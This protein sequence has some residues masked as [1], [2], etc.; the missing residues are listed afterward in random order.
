[1]DDYL[2]AISG[3]S[4]IETRATDKRVIF[5]GLSGGLLDNQAVSSIYLGEMPMS[6]ALNTFN[7][8]LVDIERVEVIKGAQGT[9]YGSAA[10]GGLIRN[11]PVA[12]SF[13]QVEGEIVFD[14]SS[15]AESNNSNNS[16]AGTLN[17][18]LIDDQVALRIAAYRT[19]NAGYVDSISTPNS[20]AIA[21]ATGAIGIVQDD[22]NASVVEG[23]RASMLWKPNDNLTLSLMLGTQKDD[24]DGSSVASLSSKYETPRL[25][26]ISPES[27]D[28][29]YFNLTAEYDMGW[30]SILSSTSKLDNKQNYE[31]SGFPVSPAFFAA[32]V[33]NTFS[34]TSLKAEEIRLITNLDGPWQVL[35]GLYYEDALLKSH[36]SLS[37]IGDSDAN[38]FGSE[39]LLESFVVLDYSQKAI[40][41]EA[42]YQFD[43]MWLLTLGGRYFDYDRVDLTT[44]NLSLPISVPES[45]ENV[46]QKGQTYKANLAFT[47]NEDVLIYAQWSEGFRLGKGQPL[48][49]LGLCDFPDGTKITT[50]VEPDTTKNIELGV[51][52]SAADSRLTINTAIFRSYWDN[53][54]VDID[55]TNGCLRRVINNI[56]AAESQ[57]IEID[58]NYII[59]DWALSISASYIDTKRVGVRSPLIEGE[60]LTYAPRTNASLGLQR[61]FTIDGIAAFVRADIAY[62]GE[63]ESAPVWLGFDS[64]GDYV[65]ANLRLGLDVEEW[66]FA[67]YA[68][69]L[70]NTNEV[71]VHADGAG[72]SGV[73]TRSH[74]RQFG[75]TLGYSF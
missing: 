67:I 28:T 47:P 39:D 40:F 70:T 37:W 6:N 33:G 23:A 29:D 58:A 68:K 24:I 59:D 34:S 57:G 19:D 14:T 8:N 1:M 66:D 10:I 35:A 42:S 38:L 44:F 9:L 13:K 26:S 52:L 55:A 20:E 16:V 72:D 73:G 30:A 25:N 51:K 61:N 54:P 62:V 60:R 15:Q 36:G 3:T 7:I 45:R 32:T 50:R 41:G 74:P 12:P 5:R 21:T 18:P 63:Y 71:L 53:L 65:N 4:Y 2:T 49:P 75:I 17:V 69:N 56:G 27:V 64:A 46:S 43:E 11:V 48:P 31:T 22:I